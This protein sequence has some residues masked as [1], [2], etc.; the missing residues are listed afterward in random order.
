MRTLFFRLRQDQEIQFLAPTGALYEMICF[1]ISSRHL[2]FEILSIHAFLYNSRVQCW[3]SNVECWM[4][5]VELQMSNIKFQMSIRLNLLMECSSRVSPVIFY[6][7]SLG[8]IFK[9]CWMSF[10]MF[11]KLSWLS[12]QERWS[13]LILYAL[14]KSEVIFSKIGNHWN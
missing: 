6:F 11:N 4:S 8:I 7:P 14:S 3:K 9:T 2:L 13:Y 5:N 10:N 1:C 12:F